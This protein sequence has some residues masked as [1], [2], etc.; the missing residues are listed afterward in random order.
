ME[1]AVNCSWSNR[2]RP[3]IG[4]TQRHTAVAAVAIALASPAFANKIT[5]ESASFGVFTGP[6]TE[7]EFTYSRLSGALF[8]NALVGNP[9]Q[10]AEGTISGGGC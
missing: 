10:D 7:N 8:V 1:S 3:L 5:F 4:D 6:V 9:G 2:F